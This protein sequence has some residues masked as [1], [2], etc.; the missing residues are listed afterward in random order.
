MSDLQVI[1]DPSLEIGAIVDLDTNLGFGPICPGPE[2]GNLLQAFVDGMPFDVGIL[3]SEQAREI[4][5]SVFRDD[6]AASLA[7]KA[8]ADNTSLVNVG[9]DDATETALATADAMASNGAPPPVAPSDTDMATHESETHSLTD[10]ATGQGDTT[11]GTPPAPVAT[12]TDDGTSNC[13]V[14]NPNGTG[15]NNAGCVVCGGSGKVRA[16]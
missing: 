3:S 13:M 12:P 10:T 8:N 2:G 9:N 4:F 1:Y 7:A 16:A 6:A 5:L 11:N 15:S 14:C